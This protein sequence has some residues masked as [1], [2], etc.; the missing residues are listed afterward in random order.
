M[1]KAKLLNADC[2]P[3]SYGCAVATM[4][5]EYFMDDRKYSG[6]HEKPFLF[7]LSGEIYVSDLKKMQDI[8]VR[9]NPQDPSI[10]ELHDIS[11]RQN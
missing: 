2:P 5:F 1:I 8:R 7:A 9:V 10:A 4:T 3:Q 11:I 6:R